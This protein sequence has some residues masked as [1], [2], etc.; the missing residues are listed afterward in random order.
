MNTPPPIPNVPAP[1]A[2]PMV[3]KYVMECRLGQGG[4]AEVFKGHIEGPGGFHKVVVIKRILHQHLEDPEFVRMFLDEARL[5][6]SLA[7]PNLV[8]IFDID[9]SDG[10]PFLAMEY[11]PGPTLHRLMR[12][13]RAAGDVRPGCVAKII[14]KICDG[15]HHAHHARDASGQPL[16]IVH[17][18]VT[19]QNIL[20]S[21]EGVPKLVDFG[22]AKAR[23]RAAT[24]SAG[25][26]K[27]KL[28]YVAP[29]QIQGRPIDGRVDVFAAG[30]VLYEATTGRFPFDGDSEEEVMQAILA[31][32]FSAPSLRMPDYPVDLERAITWALQRD[33]ERRCPSA[34]ALQEALESFVSSGQHA[35]RTQE[36]AA[37]VEAL[38]P[39]HGE[40]PELRYL[41]QAS[42]PPA[43]TRPMTLNRRGPGPGPSAEILVMTGDILPIDLT[44]SKVAARRRLDWPLFLGVPVLLLLGALS[45]GVP[46]LVLDTTVAA[47]PDPAPVVVSSAVP[48]VP[49]IVPEPAPPPPAPAP[50]PA[51]VAPPVAE[52]TAPPAPAVAPVPPTRPRPA[53]RARPRGPETPAADAPAA[54]EPD[55]GTPTRDDE[56]LALQTLRVAERHFANQDLPEALRAARL[57]I[58][59][60]PNLAA[61]HTLLGLVLAAS[62]DC[63]SANNQFAQALVLDKGDTRAQ[64]GRLACREY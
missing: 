18:D 44:T 49:V 59:L 30:V 1:S 20:V 39:S 2:A 48:V 24:T 17:R 23:G 60:N 15:L 28:R 9:E 22:V 33:L 58:A 21:G 11:V 55:P 42:L 64:A 54:V 41:G 57:A 13:A 52:E 56:A 25:V 45:L 10:I 8:Q 12:A 6:A 29:E 47:P 36:V 4:M 40:P 63:P 51:A 62:G 14:S 5:A 50:A 16:G 7:H 32:E 43:D 46:V 26:V 27:G 61:A 35:A 38:F 53:A 31:G 37:W 19:P 34:K 3:G